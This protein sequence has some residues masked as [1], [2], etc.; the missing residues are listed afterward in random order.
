M[1]SYRPGWFRVGRR[2]LL[3]L[4]DWTDW[5]VLSATSGVDRSRAEDEYTT[6]F[7]LDFV[8]KLSSCIA[9][10]CYILVQQAHSGFHGTT[11]TLGLLVWARPDAAG[12][13]KSGLDSRA[14]F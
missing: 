13:A 1:S 8:A 12:A 9:Y 5:L 14:C 3:H 7:S 10:T 2:A 4:H 6:T 11:L